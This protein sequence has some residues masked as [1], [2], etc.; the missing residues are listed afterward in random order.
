MPLFSEGPAGVELVGLVSGGRGDC[1]GLLQ[2][3]RVDTL[4]VAFLSTEPLPRRED[5]LRSQT[6]AQCGE[7]RAL[8]AGPCGNAAAQCA[9]D[10]DCSRAVA[11]VAACRSVE[12]ERSCLAANPPSSELLTL[13]RC[14]C[15]AG[16]S[17]PCA[18]HCRR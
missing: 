4:P 11:C 8:G 1:R 3:G 6:C 14:T 16:C 15:A 17:E 7:Q 12:C 2:A 13:M 18:A 10:A 9:R 5:F